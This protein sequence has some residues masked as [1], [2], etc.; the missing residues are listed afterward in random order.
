MERAVV[1]R[2][3]KSRYRTAHLKAETMA[4][5]EAL[6]HVRESIDALIQR[7]LD[8]YESEKLNPP[9]TGRRPEGQW[10]KPGERNR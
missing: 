2:A 5:L 8:S 10:P 7:L 6:L 9:A 1:Q 3:A 4:R